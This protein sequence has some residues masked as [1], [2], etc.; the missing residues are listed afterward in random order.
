[1][2][3]NDD[4]RRIMPILIREIC[5]NLC[6]IF[7]GVILLLG[8]SAQAFFSRLAGRRQHHRAL[9]DLS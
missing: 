5:V 2:D 7:E 9:K 4:I 8:A 1:M 3:E 6:P